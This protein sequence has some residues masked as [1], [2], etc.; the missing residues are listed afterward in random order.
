[1]ILCIPLDKLQGA[2]NSVR[3][4]CCFMGSTLEPHIVVNNSAQNKYIC[5]ENNFKTA[6]VL[7]WNISACDVLL[8][9]EWEDDRWWQC[10][11]LVYLCVLYTQGKKFKV[12]QWTGKLL[13]S[14]NLCKVSIP[15]RM[16]SSR[17]PLRT[18]LILPESLLKSLELRIV[19]YGAVSFLKAKP[20]A[21]IH[22][23]WC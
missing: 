6:S 9:R 4:S 7:F 14:S 23:Q 20:S 10:G 8:N 11:G 16:Q 1:M 22:P 12:K 19:W 15:N 18:V 21:F 17:Q 13:T 5:G 2:D 3:H